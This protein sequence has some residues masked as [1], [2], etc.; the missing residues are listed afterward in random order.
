MAIQI[1][2][3]AQ[4]N[5]S[6]KEEIAFRFFSDVIDQFEVLDPNTDGDELIDLLEQI[7]DETDSKA[8][9]QF[10]SYLLGMPL[11]EWLEEAVS[12]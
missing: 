6:L 8:V 4:H 1:L 2:K 10:F 3:Q 12:D 9:S 5:S 11:E 7:I